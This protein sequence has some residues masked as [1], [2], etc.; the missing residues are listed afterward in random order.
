MTSAEERADLRAAVRA[1][2]ER[3]PERAWPPLC[4]QVGVAGLLVPE[5]CGGL[6]AGLAEA[7]VVADELGRG[8]SPAPFLGSAVLATT[9]LAAAADDET[10]SR[11]LPGLAEGSVTA[12]VAWTG[13]EGRWDPDVAAC[14]ADGDVLDGTAHYVLDGADADVLLV[15]AATDDG[16]AVFEVAPGGAGVRCARAPAMD[17]SRALATV[18]LTG[19]RGRRVAGAGRA[20]LAGARDAACVALAAEQAGA[21][22]RALEITVGYCAQRRQFG[23][24]IGSFQALKHR[25]ADAYVL[26][27]TAAS[28][29]YAAAEAAEVDRPRLAAVAKAHCS[30]AFSAVAAEMIQLHGGIA[31]TWEHEAHRFFKRAHG[32]AQLFGQPHEHLARLPALVAGETG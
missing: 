31:I 1:V 2:L 15:V 22:A 27:Q 16:P 12:A 3:A 4:E 32:S 13:P 11:L 17:Q 25:L 28:A 8:L 14:A 10:R 20:A 7:A 26:V 21:A 23:R 6:G 29:A 9:L 5:H 30:E 19:A 18:T 24:P